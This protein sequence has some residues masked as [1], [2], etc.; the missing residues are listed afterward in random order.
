MNE[1]TLVLKAIARASAELLLEV[2]MKKIPG[3]SP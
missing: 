2:I 3:E 1:V